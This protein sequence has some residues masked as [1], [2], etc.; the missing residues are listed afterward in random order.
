MAIT[1]SIE[2]GMTVKT[3]IGLSGNPN[4]WWIDSEGKLRKVEYENGDKVY[5]SPGGKLHR[6][7]GPALDYANGYKAWFLN[8]EELPCETQEKF[9]RLMK[10]RAFL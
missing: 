3:A 2:N 9:E 5:Y 6:E 1:Y 8:G 7:D 10:L 4:K